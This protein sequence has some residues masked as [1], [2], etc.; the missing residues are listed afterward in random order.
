[1]ILRVMREVNNFFPVTR[2]EGDFVIENQS[3]TLDPASFTAGQ[4]VAISGSVR[5][6]GVYKLPENSFTLNNM[7]ADENFNGI[8][9]GLAPPA[10][11]L[12]LV[13]EITIFQESDLAKNNG[14]VSESFE[15]YSWTAAT[16][17]NGN[18]V[19]W[20]S[21]F[22]KELNNFRRMFSEVKL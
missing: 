15:N 21:N 1:M 19:N 4:Y 2:L 13:E 11:F 14:I 3:I 5:N 17:S 7:V 8:I 20:K 16:D 22:C 18:V 6:N 9:Y 12:E 10:D